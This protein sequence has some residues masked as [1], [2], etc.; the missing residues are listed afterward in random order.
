MSFHL[1]SLLQF[2]LTIFCSLWCKSLIFPW[3]N[4]FISIYLFCCYY[5]WHC[6]LDLIFRLFVASRNK[7]DFH[8]FIL[9]PASLLNS[10]ISCNSFGGIFFFFFA[11]FLGFSLYKTFHLQIEQ[12]FMSPPPNL[13]AF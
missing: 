11:D 1:L 9:Y 8:I 6:F 10:F 3:L 7:T 5:N 13:D 4:L 2:I 12:V